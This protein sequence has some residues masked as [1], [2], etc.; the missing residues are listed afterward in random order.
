MIY[1]RH[2]RC[3]SC[4]SAFQLSFFLGFCFTNYFVLKLHGV[5]VSF[6]QFGLFEF[7][8]ISFEI[9]LTAY[10]LNV[11]KVFEI[12]LQNF[13]EKFISFEKKIKIFQNIFSCNFDITVSSLKECGGRRTIFNSLVLSG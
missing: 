11:S 1:L 7:N 10:Y 4:A 8:Y 2:R 12:Q 9:D 3:E 6:T 13:K 5:S